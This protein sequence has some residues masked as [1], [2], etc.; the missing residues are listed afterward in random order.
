[1]IIEK[2]KNMQAYEIGKLHI[3]RNMVCQ[4]RTCFKEANGVKIISLADGAGSKF[5]SE[6][7][8]EIVCEKICEL[9]STKFIDYLLFFED[10]KINQAKH[11]KNVAALSKEIISYLVSC[12]GSNN[13]RESVYDSRYYHYGIKH[14][15]NWI[16]LVHTDV[17]LLFQ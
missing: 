17:R 5:K 13:R 8:A 6:I 3:S 1:M 9:L 15:F 7:G 16:G 11:K 10:E 4:D 12:F 14:L 2:W